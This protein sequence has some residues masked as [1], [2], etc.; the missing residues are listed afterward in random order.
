MGA[1]GNLISHPKNALLVVAFLVVLIVAGYAGYWFRDVTDV[2]GQAVI[3]YEDEP[4]TEDRIREPTRPSDATVSPASPSVDTTC[5]VLPTF[6]IERDT[7]RETNTR[8]ISRPSLDFDW[9]PTSVPEIRIGSSWLALPIIDGAPAVNVDRERT[10]VQAFDPQDGSGLTLRYPHPRSTWGLGP[11]TSISGLYG[12]DIDVHGMIG[13][14]ARHKDIKIISGYRFGT[15]IHNTG[16]T[17][18][19]SWSPSLVSW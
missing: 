11:Y 13:G 6:V 1:L 5:G 9:R 10:V 17:A 18:R 14:F 7:V 8:V 12:R 3:T 4:L 15:N 2:N 16:V 19:V